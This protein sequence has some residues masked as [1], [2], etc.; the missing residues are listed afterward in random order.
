MIKKLLII[1]ISVIIVGLAEVHAAEPIKPQTVTQQVMAT[2]SMSLATRYAVPSVNS[3]FRDNILL[4]MHYMSG[5]VKK[6]SDIKWETIRKESRHEIVIPAGKAFA[7]HDNILPEFKGKVVATTNA[8]FGPGDGFLTDGYL[9]GDGVCHLASLMNWAAQD[10]GLKVTALVNHDFAR[11]PEVDR[12]Y[13]TSIYYTPDGSRNTQ[14][15]NLYI[16][17]TTDKAVTMIVTYK[18]DTVSV[19]F[20]K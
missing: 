20:V 7:Y 11:I 2:H 3:V 4:T 14:R 19:S 15:Q 18:N 8:N 13:G 10:A 17:N 12:K 5:K 6:A 16:E 9:Y 1:I